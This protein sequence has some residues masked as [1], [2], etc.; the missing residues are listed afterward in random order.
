[1]E[2]RTAQRLVMDNKCHKGFNT[3]DIP[4]ELCLLQG[5]IIE[6]FHAWRRGQ[7]DAAEEL[8]DV[9]IYV[10]GLA[11]L[12]GVDL[13]EEITAKVEKNAQRRYERRNGVLV[14]V[15]DDSSDQ[16]ASA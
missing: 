15:T 1:L 13:Q 4:L 11:S 10:L 7:P 5:E 3:S 12:V 14:R 2:I 8:A 9:A 16:A 6:F